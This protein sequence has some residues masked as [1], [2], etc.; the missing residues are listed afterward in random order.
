MFE[1]EWINLHL[2]DIP[3]KVIRPIDNGRLKH[4]GL[5]AVYRSKTDWPISVKTELIN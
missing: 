3:I 5:N 4:S 2:N 1:T